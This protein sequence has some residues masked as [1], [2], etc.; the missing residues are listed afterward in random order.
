MCEVDKIVAP[1]KFMQNFFADHGIPRNKIV[2]SYNGCDLEVFRGFK[3]NEERNEKAVFGYVGGIAKHKGIDVLV[4][5]FNKVQNKS[6][7]LRI[8]GNCRD[9]SYLKEV[10]K[11]IHNP[12]VKIIGAFKDTREPFSE[13]DV[14]VV[15]SI[16]YE[17][18]GPLVIGE[19]HA[20]K[21]PVVASK[22]G[23]IP[24]FVD[25]WRNGLLFDMGNSDDLSE[26]IKLLATNPTLITRFQMSTSPPRSIQDQAGE[27]EE[28]YHD[29]TIGRR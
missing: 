20:T 4:E 23:C 29:L 10:R 5:A 21:T 25:D 27:L 28:L 14:L 22:V 6:T 13:I 26:K 1:S 3:K 9:S 12:S 17:T 2:C 15:P 8:Y 11:K 24:E 7:E 16:W 18:G 19:A